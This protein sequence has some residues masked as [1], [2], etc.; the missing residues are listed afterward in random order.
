[1]IELKNV[2]KKIG[3]KTILKNVNFTFENTGLFLIT[4]DNGSGK[5]TLLYVLGLLDNN[6]C[7]EYILDNVD[8]KTYKKKDLNKIRRENFSLLFSRGN[9]L[10]FLSIED[11]IFIGKKAKKSFKPKYL[12]L[13]LKRKASSLSGGEEML[14]ALERENILNKKVLLLDEI[15]SSLDNVN[16]K[17]VMDALSKQSKVK[18]VILVTHDSRIYEYGSL[19]EIRDG[20]LIQKR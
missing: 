16:L 1:M 3:D 8:V 2:T 10:T 18:L 4:G 15:T 14:V 12:D 20:E 9:L 11:N 13:D 17:K 5:S 6:F 19:L 7:G